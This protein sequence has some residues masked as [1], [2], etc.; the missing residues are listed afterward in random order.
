MVW[1][2]M[3]FGFATPV[4]AAELAPSSEKLL[5]SFVDKM[6]TTRAFQS[7]TP[8]SSNLGAK[9]TFLDDRLDYVQSTMQ[10][11]DEDDFEYRHPEFYKKVE[12]YG[13]TE[14]VVGIS[15]RQEL[16]EKVSSEA[17]KVVV[18]SP[19]IKKTFIKLDFGCG[20]YLHYPTSHHGLSPIFGVKHLKY[21]IR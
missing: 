17:P 11:Y 6:V 19:T 12:E 4:Y 13:N 16:L 15:L 2:K 3:M 20:G 14:E 10:I 7:V 9:P 8:D 18:I 21:Y 1:A 5:C